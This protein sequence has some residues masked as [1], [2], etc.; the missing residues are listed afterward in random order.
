MTTPGPNGITAEEQLEELREAVLNDW[1]I[2]TSHS[3]DALRA[4]QSTV[5]WRIT[6]PLRTFRTYTSKSKEL[7]VLPAGRLAA[8]LIARK[9]G[10]RG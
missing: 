3:T 4:M 9:L 1:V 6:R 5:S 2:V 10:G 7:G 8:A